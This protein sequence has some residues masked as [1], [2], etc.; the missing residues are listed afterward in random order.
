MRE[1]RGAAAEARLEAH[2]R[3]HGPQW[4]LALCV[5]AFLLTYLAPVDASLSDPWGTLVTA[6]AILEQGT[7]RLDAYAADP[8]WSYDPVPPAA[9]GHVY[10]YFPLGT[11]LCAVPAVALARLRG[12]DMVYPQD[13]RALQN[14]LS[15]LTVVAAALLAWALCRHFLPRSASLAVTAAFV[16]GS[17]IASTLG[18][19]LWSS[20]LALVLGLGSLLLVARAD[21]REIGWRL[22]VGLGLLV[23]FAYLCRPT[24][25][26]L[27]PALAVYLG[28]RRQR[29]PAAFVATVAGLFALFVL[30]SWREYGLLL[31]PYYQP[32]RLG[33]GGRFRQALVGHLLSPSRGILI[34]S[35]FLLLTLAGLAAWG[36][37]LARDRLAWLAGAWI[38]LHWLAISSFHHWWGG[39]SFGARLFTEALPA[40]LLLTVL[41]ARSASERLGAR[42]R[43][44][45]GAAFL[46]FAAC[47]A[48]VHSHQGLYSVYAILWNDGVDRGPSRIF[49]WRHPQ[50]LATPAS[51]GAHG[52]EH[53]LLAS[54]P[55]SPGEAIL[56]ASG[57]AI[58]EGW[59]NPEGG[60][61]WRWSKSRRPR[62]F[63][64]TGTIRAGDG[65][66]ALEI[67]AGTY[68]PQVIGV[69][70]NGVAVGTLRS[71]RNWDPA[72]Y[73]FPLPAEVFEKARRPLSGARFHELELDVPGAVLAGE[74]IQ[75]RW[76]GVCL[77]RVTLQ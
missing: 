20:N 24:M 4:L 57:K 33:T 64:K 50:F 48:F 47:A 14:A 68:R 63:F 66:L 5:I 52:R 26:L 11:S 54:P 35:P 62:V 18:T 25:A 43:T 67:E 10:D 22:E 39:W 28:W 56:P 7:I 65:E 23:F 55:V 34:G 29:I 76:L 1:I 37:R 19:A 15:S 36:R 32:S 69:R 38:A 58:F 40:F 12:Q 46:A 51:V 42:G 45:A 59:S 3:R 75:Q 53:Q 27:L 60:G 17:T 61:A 30:F 2:L 16:F 71:E 41:V 72:T 49:D 8:R 6:Q 70:L 9:N 44:A 21:R 31:P 74:G 77:R 13:N 73:R